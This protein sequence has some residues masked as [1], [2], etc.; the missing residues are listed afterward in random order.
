M[1]VTLLSEAEIR[2]CVGFDREALEAVAQGF[3]RLA[4]GRAFAP[5]VIAVEIPRRMARSTSR[6]LTSKA[7]TASP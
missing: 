2:G 1:S 3:S 6:P 7:S 4:E 5:P